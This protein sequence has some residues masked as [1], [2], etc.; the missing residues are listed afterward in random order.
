MPKRMWPSGALLRNPR[1]VNAPVAAIEKMGAHHQTHQT[2][3]IC[4]DEVNRIIST[5]AY[6][7]THTLGNLLG[8]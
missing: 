8:N 6:M 1:S 5:P 7:R 4:V 3:E 2:T